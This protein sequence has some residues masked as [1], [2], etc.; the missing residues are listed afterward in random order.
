MAGT[1][2]QMTGACSN[3]NVGNNTTCTG[4]SKCNQSYT[5]QSGVCTGSNPVTCM[6]MG[7]CPVAGTCDPTSGTCSN[8]TAMDGTGCGTGGMQCQGG[9]CQC[10]TGTTNCGGTCVNEQTDANNCGRCSHPCL[11]GG[12]CS[13][14]MCQPILMGTAMGTIADIATDGTA[15]VYTDS[16]DSTVDEYPSPGGG[17]IELANSN[18]GVSGPVDIGID[19]GSGAV[20]WTQS[21]GSIGQA[22]KGVVASAT[23]NLILTSCQTSSPF[24]LHVDSSGSFDVLMGGALFTC[25]V[26]TGEVADNTTGLPTGTPGMTLS[27]RWAYGISG[28][29]A[30][31]VIFGSAQPTPAAIISGQPGVNYTWDDGTYAYW[32]TSDPAIRRAAFATPLTVLTVVTNTGGTVGGLTT[33]GT[34]VYYETPSGMFYAP[35]AGGSGKPLVSTTGRFLKYGS[36]AVFFAVANNLYKVATP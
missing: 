18:N 22:Q 5:C 25:L 27:P 16:G 33:D 2:N 21:D 19:P 32:A 26:G 15:V 28:A 11:T 35:V 31:A 12:T 29:S 4:T 34:N 3:P 1:C 8:P 14:G 23:T 10:P 17:K 36:G 20:F 13:G 24:A 7:V 9:A 6:A 30:N